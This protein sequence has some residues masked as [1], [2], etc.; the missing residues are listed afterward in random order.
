MTIPLL[1]LG[2]P[3]ALARHPRTTFALGA[4]S[5]LFMLAA[6]SVQPEVP[7]DIA[8]PIFAHVLPHFVRG[9]LSI[10]EQSFADLRP[11][12]AD[13]KLPDRHDAFLA[14]EIAG[15]PGLVALLPI[16]AMWFLLGR[17]ALAK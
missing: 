15:L 16:F 9:E 17:R 10:G 12:R 2:L 3:I 7:E 4:L 13:P 6:T 8:N 14:G 11:A 5:V 1:A